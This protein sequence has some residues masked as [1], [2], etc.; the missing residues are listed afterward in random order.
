MADETVMN[1]VHDA[2]HESVVDVILNSGNTDF[3]PAA[4]T[5]VSWLGNQWWEI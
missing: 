3:M 1:F 4:A 5:I 2:V